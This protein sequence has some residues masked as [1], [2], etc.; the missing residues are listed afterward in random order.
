[1]TRRVFPVF[2]IAMAS[3]LSLGCTRGNGPSAETAAPHQA[4]VVLPDLSS[5]AESVQRQVRER[6]ALLAQKLGNQSTARAELAAAHGELGRLLM[7]SKFTDEAAS[8][9]LHAEALVS[10][11]MRWPYYLGHAYL[12]KGD[13]VRAAEDRKSVV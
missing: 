5:L 10:D 9:Y 2:A 4:P 1:M 7:A 13:R 6:Y 11:D 8:C 3:A 12:R